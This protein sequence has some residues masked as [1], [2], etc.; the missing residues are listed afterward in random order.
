MTPTGMDRWEL[1]WARTPAQLG[2]DQQI[3]W[4]CLVPRRAIVARH[5]PGP[6]PARGRLHDARPD[7]RTVGLPGRDPGRAPLTSRTRH[8]FAC[9]AGAL[10]LGL[11]LGI[12]TPW[13]PAIAPD[14]TSYLNA[15]QSLVREGALRQPYSDWDA[16]RAGA[17]LTDY[18]P[19]FSL[20][21]AVPVA[22]GVR[23]T[24]AA[25]WSEAL[26]A[27]GAVAIVF[28]LVGIL[29]GLG[30]AAS[31]VLLLIAMPAMTE[32]HLWILSEPLFILLTV[33][34][35]AAMLLLPGR[36]WL[37]G[38]LA[39]LADLTR[40]AG[41]FLVGTV[42]LW[43]VLSPGTR[44]ERLIRAATALAPGALLQLWWQHD[45]V[46]PGGKIS[47][48]AFAGLG[49]ALLEGTRTIE[50]W[51]VP[52][53]P[54]GAL[55]VGLAVALLLLLKWCGWRAL[56]GADRERRPFFL[57]IL[58]T[59]FCYVGML[60]FAR[61]HVVA[62]VPFD[63]R[64]L[65]PLFV[66]LTI[67]TVPTLAWRWRGWGIPLR[68]FAAIV[69]VAWLVGALRHDFR[70]VSVARAD[71]LG[72]ESAE[73]TGSPVSRWLADSAEG[74]TIYTN[75]P[76]GVW[77]VTGHAVHLLPSSLDPDTVRAFA[78]R[79]GAAPSV[80]IG[81]DESFMPTASPHSLAGLLGLAP[82]ARS[83]RGTAWV[84]PAPSPR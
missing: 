3:V 64:I 56:L 28:E 5:H 79:F 72:Y 39:M 52:G 50:A 73:W 66:V 60:V 80:I 20:I 24:V 84:P 37:H 18:A 41:I 61:L 46:S 11:V 70:S 34:T 4:R 62:D 58:L 38:L 23:P 15:A 74:R 21:L 6:A 67:G 2:V 68:A 78:A 10:T 55:R 30:A 57:A 14:S 65:G 27:G 16:A 19:G 69:A 29:A 40:Y 8:T 22:F 36:A 47:K 9:L 76:P 53:V 33:A 82:A 31:T 45:G 83:E 17:R 71:G 25:R 42:T 75:D 26:A 1:R 49:A 7:R 48:D 32:I 51:L 63:D 59:S 77:A 13:G 44:R 81:Y 43:Q 35:L 12:D 54:D